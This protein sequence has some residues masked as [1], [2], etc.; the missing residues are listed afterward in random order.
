AFG[1]L[2]GGLAGNLIDRIISGYVIDFLDFYIFKY[3]FP[4]FNVADICI[5][6][7]V[8][9]LIYATIKG[10]D[11]N[12]NNSNRSKRKTRQISSK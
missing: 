5:V 2:Y 12:V 8:L 10:E 1:L 11:E 3:D 9:L 6:L 4:V 7:G